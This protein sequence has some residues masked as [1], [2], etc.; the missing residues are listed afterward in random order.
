MEH[1]EDRLTLL[2]LYVRCYEG[3]VPSVWDAWMALSYL[4]AT[5]ILKAIVASGIV[6]ILARYFELES[7]SAI[8]G[9]AVLAI[10]TS[11]SHW[12]KDVQDGMKIFR[13]LRKELRKEAPIILAL[14]WASLL[15]CILRMCAPVV[16]VYRGIRAMWGTDAGM[17]RRLHEGPVS[18]PARPSRAGSGGGAAP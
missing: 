10:F 18:A 9:M 15:W 11:A 2:H 16:W 14:M 3:H 6:T 13:E 4:L 8:A 12:I 1:E 17:R 5:F 7:R